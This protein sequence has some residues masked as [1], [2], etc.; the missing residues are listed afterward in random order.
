MLVLHAHW[1][2]PQNSADAGGVLFWAEASDSPAPIR[3]R[4]RRPR[5]VSIRDHPFCA[6][7]SALSPILGQAGSERT[8][9]LRLPS[10]RSGPLP[11]P[12]LARAWESNREI[13][14]SLVPWNV[15]GLVITPSQALVLLVNLP[16]MDTETHL[17][18]AGDDARFWHKA[19]ALAM[20][21]LAA[22]K[23]APTLTR[24]D[25]DGKRFYARWAPVL[26]GPKDAQRLSQLQAAMPPVC[27][28]GQVS[29]GEPLS[30]R[31]IL[32]T[33]LNASCDDAAR[34]WAKSAAPR[35]APQET[36]AE[37]EWVQALFREDPQVK[38]SPAQGQALETSYRAWMRN[39]NMAGD[40][41]FRVA[42]RLE[43]PQ[44]ISKDKAQWK[45]HFLLQARDDPTLLIP[46]QQVWKTSGNVLTQLGRRFEQPQD[47][48]LGGLGYAARLYP[49]IQKSLK[50]KRP[51]HVA[52][53]TQ[54]AYDFLRNASPLLE[55]AG[56][57]L[58]APP[59]W[60]QPGTRLGM[61]LRLMPP[62]GK[63]VEALAKGQMS[64]QKLVNYQWEL[65][66]GETSL[67][68][69]EFHS[70]AALKMPLVQVRGQWVQLDPEQVEAAIQFW[71]E[72]ASSGEMTL[73][74]ALQFGLGGR[75][76]AESPACG[77]CGRR[78]LGRG[79]AGAFAP[80]GSPERAGSTQRPEWSVAPIPAFR[81][82]LAGISASL[83]AGRLPGR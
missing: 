67:T 34:R 7:P 82:F 17:F 25:S 62:P 32:L 29:Q 79:M 76:K 83:W 51:D 46:A 10:T 31:A 57:G 66:L 9:V 42:F 72:Q 69:Q 37:V 61:R 78:R 15:S 59:W 16:S 56:F 28:A 24:G 41:Y 4:G 81:L 30:A 52:L 55:E 27:R 20:E 54:A 39:L 18:T 74:E 63:P 33:F 48:M 21:T 71:K 11:S 43:T 73:I 3:Q 77:G 1:L 2:P 40:A 44:D 23:L 5:R 26:D 38:V 53:D 22:Q 65:S 45:I 6:P 58:L 47:K 36:G 75:G 70:L 14:P 50:A 12:R 68:E 19:A 8:C 64:F 13:K 80:A 49:P 60:N 35:F